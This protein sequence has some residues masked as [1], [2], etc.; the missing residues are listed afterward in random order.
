[1]SLGSVE[2]LADILGGRLFGHFMELS[3]KET[4]IRVNEADLAEGW[5]SYGTSVRRVAET[6]LRLPAERVL[7]VRESRGADGR[8]V[9]WDFK[10]DKALLLKAPFIRW[11]RRGLAGAEERQRM[12]DSTARLKEFR[13]KS[14]QGG[15]GGTV[16]G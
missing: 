3:E 9:F 7:S 4:I 15:T 16:E 10:L 5:F 2:S 6:V 8:V 11:S 12:V 1:M 14:T 13:F